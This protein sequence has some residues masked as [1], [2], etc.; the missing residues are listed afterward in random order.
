ML[1]I[2][3]E[4]PAAEVS[5]VVA[6]G[7]GPPFGPP[8]E[9]VSLAPALGQNYPNPV[10]ASTRIPYALDTEADVEITLV[11][12]QGRRVYAV[13]R[14]RVRPGDREELLDLSDPMLR[15]LPNGLY[16]YVLK[17]WNAAPEGRRLRYRAT[18]RLVLLR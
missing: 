12:V 17:V 9:P 7:I 6:T 18:R 5:R 16:F 3:I 10:S 14:R 8:D 11:D 4:A 13:T 2:Q 1:T 15:V